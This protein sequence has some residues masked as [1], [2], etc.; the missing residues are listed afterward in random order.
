MQ[1]STR[2]LFDRLTELLFS[3][4]QVLI[5]AKTNDPQEFRLEVAKLCSPF[6]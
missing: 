5:K 4:H 1:E 6:V 2:K 3:N